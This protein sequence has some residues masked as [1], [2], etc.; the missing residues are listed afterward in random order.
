MTTIK[1]ITITDSKLN[2]FYNTKGAKLYKYE[3]NKENYTCELALQGEFKTKAECKNNCKPTPSYKGK[4]TPLEASN[5]IITYLS[6]LKGLIGNKDGVDK[7]FGKNPNDAINNFADSVFLW[8]TFVNENNKIPCNNVAYYHQE[9]EIIFNIECERSSYPDYN[10]LGDFVSLFDSKDK[11]LNKIELGL[12]LGNA[13]NESGF[14]MGLFNTCE[15]ENTWTYPD[16]NCYCKSCNGNKGY[17]IKLVGR[18]LLQISYMPNYS[19][20]SLILNKMNSI[21]TG[22]LDNYYQKIL[23]RLPTSILYP[24]LCGQKDMEGNYYSKCKSDLA[25]DTTINCCQAP[26]FQQIKE[27]CDFI[28]DKEN[29]ILTNPVSVCSEDKI[30]I[31]IISSFAYASSQIS[32]IV[33]EL[34]YSFKVEACTTN[35]GGCVYPIKANDYDWLEKKGYGYDEVTLNWVNEKL[36]ACNIEGNEDRYRGFCEIMN[37][38]FPKE[39]ITSTNSWSI[40]L[41]NGNRYQAYPNNFDA[42]LE[43]DI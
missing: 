29:T 19:A 41:K 4:L 5:D 31:S 14:N 34:D 17:D 3:C 26:I 7:A 25:S 16:T 39:N 10:Y 40:N 30:P 11:E 36:D 2:I 35:Q 9:G 37:L 27:V 23:D 24:P 42:K 38:L 12:M 21:L 1:G 18:G 22:K 33:K 13:W 8:N 32:T 15:Q 28:P 6:D 20:I 43:Y